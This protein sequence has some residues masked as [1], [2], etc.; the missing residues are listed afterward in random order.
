MRFWLRALTLGLGIA[1]T[2]AS[3]ALWPQTR[4]LGPYIFVLG[5]CLVPV[6]GVL[7]LLSWI[8]PLPH[9]RTVSCPACGTATRVLSLPRHLPYTCRHCKRQGTIER[10]RITLASQ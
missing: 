8:I 1:L 9:E 2:G 6:G 4:E 7:A 3:L 5:L 10:G